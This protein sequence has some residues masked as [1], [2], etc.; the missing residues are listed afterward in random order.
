MRI[1]SLCDSY[2]FKKFLK[3][4]I[5]RMTPRFKKRN[6]FSG[7]THLYS[8]M[9][10]VFIT[11]NESFNVGGISRTPWKLYEGHFPLWLIE[12]GPAR[13]FYYELSSPLGLSP[14][15]NSLP[16]HVFWNDCTLWY[17]E[18]IGNDFIN[19]KRK[20]SFKKCNLLFVK[21]I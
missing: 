9:L 17:F 13:P 8:P 16:T 15:L 14:K 11:S 18:S 7:I 6:W 19:F 20:Y 12:M 1:G 21:F 4:Y 10:S 3:V 2:P 5:E